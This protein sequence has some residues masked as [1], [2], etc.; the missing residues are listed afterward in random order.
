[1]DISE[2]KIIAENFCTVNIMGLANILKWILY[3]YTEQLLEKIHYIIVTSLEEAWMTSDWNL[4]NIVLIFRG[5][6]ESRR[7]S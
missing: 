5:G 3:E 2:T 4:A 6:E 7:P 1:M